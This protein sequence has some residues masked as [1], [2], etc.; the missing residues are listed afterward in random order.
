MVKVPE[1]KF[2]LSQAQTASP[3][4]S[5]IPTPSAKR[6]GASIPFHKRVTPANL[7]IREPQLE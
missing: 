7:G 5:S 1:S 4:T 6:C 2:M 3:N